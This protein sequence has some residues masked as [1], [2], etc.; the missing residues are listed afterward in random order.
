METRE[1]IR[2]FM[3]EICEWITNHLDR[4][5]ETRYE[6][7]VKADGSLVTKSDLYVEK[8]VFD[9][10]RERLDRAAFIGEESFDFNHA[11]SDQY[12]VMLDPIDGT[13]NFCAGLKEWGVAFSM[14]RQNVHLGSFL[15][16]PEL[17]LRLMTGDEFTPITSRMTGLS[18]AITERLIAI[19]GEPGEYRMFGCS[20]YNIYN[21]I[22]GSFA[23]FVHPKGAYVWDILP[24]MMLALEH[25]CSVFVDDEP[26][27][28]RF[29]APD[30]KYR[31]D[32]RSGM[33][34]E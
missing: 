26:Y 15:F 32:I 2:S 6:I 19:L 17:N 29:L 21:V 23:R 16:M 34:G 11:A 3:N 30:R 31:V 20:V 14:W 9:F 12:I 27:D 18:C 28:G 13:E 33:G 1:E 22:R 25:G 10:V 4:I 24:G 7:T 5:E 8:L